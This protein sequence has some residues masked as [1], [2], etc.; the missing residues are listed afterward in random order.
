MEPKEIKGSHKGSRQ[1]DA[2][3]LSTSGS[4][5]SNN[6]NVEIFKLEDTRSDF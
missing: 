2:G 4:A 3:S 5:G 6:F 1:A